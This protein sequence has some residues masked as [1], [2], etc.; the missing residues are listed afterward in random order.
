MFWDLPCLR[1]PFGA[2]QLE[3]M[4]QEDSPDGITVRD[5]LRVLLSSDPT[6]TYV[7]HDVI[8]REM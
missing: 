4:A 1:K 2:G 6:N 3:A 8:P 7:L 5:R